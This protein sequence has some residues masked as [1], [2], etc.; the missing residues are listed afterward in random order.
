M[1]AASGATSTRSGAISGMTD[2]GSSRFSKCGRGSDCSLR[3]P[4]SR[5]AS[6]LLQA[7]I[8]ADDQ[9]FRSLSFGKRRQ[10]VLDLQLVYF[11]GLMKA[12]PMRAQFGR[13]SDLPA[14]TDTGIVEPVLRSR[15]LRNRPLRAKSRF[16]NQRIVDLPAMRSEKPGPLAA[17]AQLDRAQKRRIAGEQFR[18]RIRISCV[19]SVTI[20]G[21]FSDPLETAFEPVVRTEL[22]RSLAA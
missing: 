1:S 5:S 14:K 10:A 17:R 21:I 7:V 13:R 11:I 16:R 18:D 22:P 6:P 4:S 12:S 3:K 8:D 20:D 19:S 2:I 15:A 9:L